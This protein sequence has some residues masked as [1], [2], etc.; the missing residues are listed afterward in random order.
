M[1]LG[2]ERTINN[3]RTR[4]SGDY[5]NNICNAIKDTAP[6]SITTN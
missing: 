2:R 1:G 5:S 4:I 6:G 3:S